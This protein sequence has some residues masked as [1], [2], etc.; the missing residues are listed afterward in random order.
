MS[1]RI[2]SNGKAPGLT[3]FPLGE[4]EMIA[5]ED[6]SIRYRVPHE[7]IFTFKEYAIRSLQRRI[8][9][10]EFWALREVSL[11]VEKGEVFGVIGP[12]G[13][14]KSTLLKLVA[15]VLHP[16]R[17]RVVVRGEVAPLLEFGA[18]FHPELTGHENIYLF[19]SLL[20]RTSREVQERFES[21][22]AFAELGDFIEAPLRT[23]SSGMVA[24]L[25]FA[26]ATEWVPDV[27]LVDEVLAVGDA[28]FSEKSATRMR[29]FR[30]RG[31][32]ILLVSHN[33][34][35]IRKMCQK[36]LWLQAGQARAIGPPE[37]VIRAYLGG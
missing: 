4:R 19:G 11:R 24:R 20:G 17:G 18:A 6:V 16:T 2:G 9:L 33:M 21:I 10:D 29:S 3:A 8:N 15:R 32:T 34:E 26:I 27:L 37:D 36:V 7:R 14:G 13:A 35:A 23:Y 22:V 28:A 5:L 30:E 31:V 12:N 1:S 25:G